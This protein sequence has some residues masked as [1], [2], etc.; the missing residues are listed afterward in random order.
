M[1]RTHYPYLA[2]LTYP[3][4]TAH[5]FNRWGDTATF[6]VV[7]RDMTGVRR[8]EPIELTQWLR[9]TAESAQANAAQQLDDFGGEWFV[10]PVT[11][12]S[13]GGLCR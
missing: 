5:T 3:D 4:G 7:G 10:V 12:T 1:P 8:G 11:Y 9:G 2:H 6:A 13:P